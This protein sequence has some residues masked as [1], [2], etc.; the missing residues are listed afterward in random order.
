[1]Q[2]RIDHS[3]SPSAREQLERQ[4]LQTRGFGFAIPATDGKVLV[5]FCSW[6]LTGTAPAWAFGRFAGLT[7]WVLP[8]IDG[9]SGMCNRLPAGRCR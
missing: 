2:V 3:L 8:G 1:M 4:V 5:G 6:G 9:S 7:P